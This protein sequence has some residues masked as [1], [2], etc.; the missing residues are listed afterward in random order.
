MIFHECV[1]LTPKEQ[2]SLDGFR[3][4]LQDNRIV[5]PEGYDDA[6]RLIQRF[7]EGSQFRYK[8]AYE[9]L[10][11]HHKFIQTFPIQLHE[12]KAWVEELNKGYAYVYKRDR[13]F[14]PIFHMNL[15]KLKKVKTDHDTLIKMCSFMIQFIITRAL[16]P[17]KIENWVTVIDFKDVGLTEVPKKLIQVMT[18]PLQDLFKGRLFK[19]YIINAGFVMKIV[20]GIAKQVID[21]LTILKFKMEGEK[22][23]KSLHE[24]IDPSQL[25]KRFGGTLPDKEDKFFPP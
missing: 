24:L 8:E 20:Y 23:H 10:M 25:E 15:K 18:K 16:I 21:P 3:K 5:L 6:E 22:F 17:G 13:S 9:S 14:R 11:V 12:Y 2:A 19:L 1:G 7:L 4:Y